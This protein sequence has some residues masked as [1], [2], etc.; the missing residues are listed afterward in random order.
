MFAF[1]LGINICLA[2]SQSYL[3]WRG[4]VSLPGLTQPV[5]LTD[6]WLVSM[7]P[8]YLSHLGWFKS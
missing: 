2:I 4:V 3:R 7:K 5:T 8:F 6:G 1:V